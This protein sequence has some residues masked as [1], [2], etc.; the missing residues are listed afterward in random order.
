MR[1]RVPLFSL[2]FFLVGITAN[3]AATRDIRKVVPLDPAGRVTVES[4][5]GSVT[6][7][8]WDQP[9][10]GIDARIEPAEYGGHPEDVQK[11]NVAI[12]GQGTEVRI[13]SDYSA[14]PTH[15][16]WFGFSQNLP[17]VHYTIHMPATGRLEVEVHNAGVN[18][19]GV[20]DVTVTTHNGAV[21]LA[22]LAG[23]AKVETHNGSIRL[24][25]VQYTAPAR[26]ATHNGSCTV[27][28]PPASRMTLRADTHTNRP[29]TS[30]LPVAVSSRGSEYV[31]TLNGGGP[32]LRFTAHNGSL[33]L[34]GR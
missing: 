6:V 24:A 25:Y 34:S 8:T 1:L 11:V 7:A 18:V 28:V 29:I 12:E 16:G 9:N 32:E 2:L 14:V 5:N 27:T 15:L 10:V 21:N 13:E 22:N 17:P 31:A 4:H 3:A 33:E 23:S 20:R 19:N 30:N 26:I